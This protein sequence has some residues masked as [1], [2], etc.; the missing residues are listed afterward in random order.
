MLKK[1][2]S[3]RTQILS[4]STPIISSDDKDEFTI[5]SISGGYINHSFMIKI[6]SQ[7]NNDRSPHVFFVK[8][9]LNIHAKQMFEA[10]LIGSHALREVCT[11]LIRIPQPIVSGN[12]YEI[13]N[14]NQGGWFLAE[15]IP[16]TSTK[17][18]KTDEQYRRFAQAVVK[19]HQISAEKH[20]LSVN[21][22]LFGFHI[23]NFYIHTEQENAWNSDW[24]SFYLEQ[25][26]KP[27][28]LRMK[29]DTDFINSYNKNMELILLC[30]RLIPHVPW[31]LK[32]IQAQIQPCL[33]HG[34][35]NDRNWSFDETGNMVMFDGSPFFGPYE[36]DIHTM[37]HKFIQA[38]YEAIGG[39]I[40]GYEI[41]FE[42]YNLV[43]LLRCIVDIGYDHWRSQTVECL[44][45]LLTHCGAWASPLVRFPCGSKIPLD[46]IN[47]PTNVDSKKKNAILVY[48][49]SFCPIHLNHL[50]VI[51]FVAEVLE[52]P[53][54]NFEILG[55]YF[56][57]SAASWVTKKLRGKNLPDAHR[58]A[59]LLL[60][61]EGT[62]WMVN[63]SY[64]S[65]NKLSQAILQ[66]LNNLF[67]EEF[68]ISVVHI[69]GTDAIE[70]NTRRVSMQ[71]P[72]A[73]VDRP[74]YDSETLWK[75]FLAN[76]TPD[77]RE[78]LIW[79]APWTGEMR[80]STQIRQLLVNATSN[81]VDVRQ[82]LR[83]LV[84]TS[85]IDYILEHNIGH[86]FR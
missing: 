26:L 2:S 46:K 1:S 43:R 47:R 30:D 57:P 60:A 66:E 17:Q 79:I 70:N 65:P 44:R 64:C 48:G 68:N 78:R 72:L 4:S 7:E 56:C 85:C 73:V 9:N 58:E 35:L 52:K 20:K 75:D 34:D 74:G 81:H 61:T 76:T 31:F 21:S 82:C 5:K 67:G 6:N 63:R 23:N 37:P 62:R 54:Y 83:D 50:A 40:D 84:P 77:N 59:L 80:S 15:Y 53:P 86:W 42:L 51:D 22:G 16:M 3:F 8:I 49:G 69:C 36:F 13:D 10:E 39:S 32:T 11:P 55:G 29:C 71:Y 45:R 25:R 24:C 38:Y 28:L 14:Y 19:M 12:L 33:L 27:V 18:K 41:R